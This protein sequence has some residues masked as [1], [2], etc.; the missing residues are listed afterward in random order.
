MLSSY[1]AESFFAQVVWSSHVDGMIRTGHLDFGSSQPGAGIRMLLHMSF[2]PCVFG[3]FAVKKRR[4][5]R[6]GALTI[7]G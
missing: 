4:K 3:G 6:F 5:I 2:R 1:G 7:A